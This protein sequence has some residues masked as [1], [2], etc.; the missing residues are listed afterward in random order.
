M[1]ATEF[2]AA[3]WGMLPTPFS[4]DGRRVCRVSLESL[5][6]EMLA[7]GCTG[8]IAL[9]VIGEP[10][11]LSLDEKLTV[12]DTVVE[13]S[14]GAPVVATVMSLDGA[15]ATAEIDA[16]TAAFAKSLAAV[17][18]PVRSADP[19]VVRRSIL[20]VHEHSGLPVLVQD[21]PSATGISIEIDALIA[22]LNGL[23]SAL[24]GVKSEAA[25][26]FWRIRRILQEMETTVMAGNGGIGLV[27]DHLAGATW[28]AAGISRPEIIV[29]AVRWLTEGK[30]NRAQEVLD[31][32]SA[33]ISLET[34]SSTSIGIR[35]EHWRRQG[36]I[37]SA[38][39]RF[40]TVPYHPEFGIHSARQGLEAS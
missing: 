3:V 34:Q 4:T 18:I 5:T 28:T 21:L 27:D 32:A 24:W 25:P 33:L 26:T 1:N 7:R 13:V 17:M 15:T 19:A 6:R 12:L 39:V 40:P 8:T 9:G 2:P 20:D 11:A 23:D 10:G 37:D 16:I 31:S 22:A 38:S 35:K 36:V 29:G 14:G 30:I